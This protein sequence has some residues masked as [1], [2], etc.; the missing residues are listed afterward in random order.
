MK[1]ILVTFLL[2]ATLF[3]CQAKKATITMEEAKNI[4]LKDITGDVVRSSEKKLNGD[5]YYEFDILENDVL[6]KFVISGEGSVTDYVR[7]TAQIYNEQTN[8]TEPTVE[9]AQPTAEVTATP[10]TTPTPATVAP[11]TTEEKLITVDQAN[12]IAI[13]RVGGGTVTECE[14]DYEGGVKHYDIEVQY[15]FKE[16]DVTVNAVT[17]AIIGFSQDY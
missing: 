11:A 12:A 13:K 3:G 4:A 7:E 16:Y 17:G 5:V 1:K 2:A 6:H 9:P 8:T 10:A 15:N 14:F